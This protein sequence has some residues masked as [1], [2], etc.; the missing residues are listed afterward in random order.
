MA[1]TYCKGCAFAHENSPIDSSCDFDILYHIKNIKDID[2]KNNYYYINNYKCK[3][4]FSKETLVKNQLDI[5]DI[6]SLLIN[7]A[8]LQYYLIIDARNLIKDSDFDNLGN[9]INSLDIFPK[10]VSIIVNIYNSNNEDIY[11][12]LY[13]I[14]DKKIKWKLHAF[15]KDISFNEAANVAA[16]TNIQT[17]ES[18]IIYFWDVSVT[19]YSVTNNRINHVFFRKNIQ[20]DNIFGFRSEVFDGLCIPITLYKSIITLMDRDILKALSTIKEIVLEEYE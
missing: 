18:S 20:Q 9:Q 17:S 14:I 11:R 4:A 13:N 2:I 12:R 15:L 8:H 6:K 1:N 3:Y 16:E 5:N 10:T 7:K 19:D